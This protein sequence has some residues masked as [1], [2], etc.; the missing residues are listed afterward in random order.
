MFNLIRK[1]YMIVKKM[2]LMVMVVAVLIPAFLSFAGGDVVI[3]SVLT[4]TS[5]SILVAM[6]LFS[7][8]DEEEAK[9]PKAAALITTIG[10]G[11]N[12]QVIKRYVLMGMVY[13]YSLVIYVVESMFVPGLGE[14]NLL[15]FAISLFCFAVIAA[16]YLL[17]TTLFGVRAGRYIVMA[18]IVLI[19]MGPTIIKGLNIK[20]NM[21][22]MGNIN[23]NI[24]IA[25]LM[26]VAILVYGVS[27]A[28][29]MT[30]YATKEL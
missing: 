27:L 16:L 2:W 5:M 25:A 4:I 22:F 19:S 11:R 17:L 30:S 12:I 9:Y 15:S 26:G 24:L 10:Y 7:S 18:F 21:D 20:I 23:E 3:P 14:I 8:I 1:D 28:V 13:L 29:S 6:I